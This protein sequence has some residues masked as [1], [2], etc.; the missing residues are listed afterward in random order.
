MLQPP[1]EGSQ[2]RSEQNRQRPR[3][4][5]VNTIAGFNGVG[6]IGL[7]TQPRPARDVTTK[8]EN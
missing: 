1:I 3:H 8:P 6:L 5:T 7:E 4:Q 2:R